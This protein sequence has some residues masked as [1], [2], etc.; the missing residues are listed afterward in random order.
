[1][2]SQIIEGLFAVACDDYFVGQVVLREARKRQLN[3]LWFGSSSTN[4]IRLD[5]SCIGLQGFGSAT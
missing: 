4:K 5:H 1:M 3:I 2:M